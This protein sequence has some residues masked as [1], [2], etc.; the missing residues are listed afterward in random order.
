[1]SFQRGEES[2]VLRCKIATESALSG[3]TIPLVAILVGY[4]NSTA[5]VNAS[6]RNGR[7]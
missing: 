5:M 7:D 6:H 1:M 2:A 4:R 3:Y